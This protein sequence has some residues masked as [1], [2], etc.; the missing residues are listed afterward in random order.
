MG[1]ANFASTVNTTFPRLTYIT[2]ETKLA[3]E[4]RL[5][6]VSTT[7]KRWKE[8]E[9][10]RGRRGPFDRNALLRYGRKSH[11][12]CVVDAFHGSGRTR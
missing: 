11:Q 7:S 2:S 4:R 1:A 5:T 3:Y 8:N 9:N 10:P 6:L 12:S